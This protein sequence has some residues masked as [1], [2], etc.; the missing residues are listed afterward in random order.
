MSIGS[1][2][3]AQAD[4]PWVAQ[5]AAEALAAAHANVGAHVYCDTFSDVDRGYFARQGVVDRLYN[6]RPAFHVLRHL[7]GALAAAGGGAW[8]VKAGAATVAGGPATG[9]GT[10]VDLATG[11]VQPGGA[12]ALVK[13][14]GP[15]AWIAG[16]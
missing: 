7:T 13:A 15:A 12:D 16:Q 9:A 14:S 8:A 2:G 1:P 6:P 3:A 10:L 4:E 5:R 11:Q